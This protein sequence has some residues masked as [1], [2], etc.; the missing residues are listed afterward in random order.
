MP[1][2]DALNGGEADTSAFELTFSMQTL[3]YTEEFVGVLHVKSYAIIAH[4]INL[5]AVFFQTPHLDESGVAVATVFERVSDQV[6]KNLLEKGGIS[7]HFGQGQNVPAN[8]AV[9]SFGCEHFNGGIHQQARIDH[10]F[11]G[12]LAGGT[13]K[14]Q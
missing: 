13:R 4:K 14:S 5:F 11:F 6:D 9:F 3:E 12:I 1:V 7:L 2:D 8:L 10:L